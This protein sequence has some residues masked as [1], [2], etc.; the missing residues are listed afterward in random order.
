MSFNLEKFFTNVFDPKPGEVVVIIYDKPHPGCSREDYP[1]WKMRREMA[2][3]WYHALTQ[4]GRMSNFAVFSI[5]YLATGQNNGDLPETCCVN[6]RNFPAVNLDWFLKGASIILAM[7]EFSATAPLKAYTKAG[8]LRLGSMPGLTEEMLNTGLAADFDKI[9][10]RCGKLKPL[11]QKAIVALVKF[12]TG[13]EIRFDLCFNEAHADNGDLRQ[14][15]TFANL[16]PGEVFKVPNEANNSSTNG[17]IPIM[18][19]GILHVLQVQANEIVGA[20]KNGINVNLDGLFGNSDPAC[21]NIAEFAIGVNESATVVGRTL[22]DEKVL[23]FHWARGRSEHLGGTVGPAQFQD[24]KNV[25]HQDY[26][27]PIAG[28]DITVQEVCLG[29]PSTIALTMVIENGRFLI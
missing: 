2:E 14:G 7:T 11:M 18:V 20:T 17:E 8:R 12:S 5:S 29:L 13:H 27:Y 4:L 9:K 22:Q 19:D 10:E 28:A 21:R 3:D 6:G 25:I 26:V 23:G 24:P 16:P 1:N 15:D